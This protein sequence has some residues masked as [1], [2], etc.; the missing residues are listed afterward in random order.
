LVEGAAAVV[1]ATGIIE[2]VAGDLITM[3][4]TAICAVA[5]RRA[6]GAGIEMTVT[7]ETVTVIWM[8]VEIGTIVISG[9]G[10]FD[11]NPIAVPY[12]MNSHRSP[13]TFLLLPS[14]L[15]LQHS[16]PYHPGT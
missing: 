11:L 9:I 12:L 15:L 14:P 8:R 6:A 1:V 3:I 2:D 10:T 5:P 7:G 13:K 4:V 16:A